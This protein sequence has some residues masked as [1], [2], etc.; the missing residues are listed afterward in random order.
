MRHKWKTHA[1][2][3]KKHWILP[4]IIKSNYCTHWLYPI[5]LRTDVCPTNFPVLSSP[6]CLTLINAR[7]KKHNLMWDSICYRTFLIFSKSFIIRLVHYRRPYIFSFALLHH[8]LFAQSMP[9]A[10]LWAFWTVRCKLMCVREF[11]LIGIQPCL[12]H[13]VRIVLLD[14]FPTRAIA[15]TTQLIGV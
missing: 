5:A 11:G 12:W 13:K 8:P 7:T 14:I 6:V 9:H 10:V 3:H 4:N 2:T 15:L 1:R